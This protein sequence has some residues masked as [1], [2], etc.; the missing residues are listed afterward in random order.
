MSAVRLFSRAIFISAKNS[1]IYFE[2]KAVLC[3]YFLH[4]EMFSEEMA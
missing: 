1:D 4:S 3:F 2:A